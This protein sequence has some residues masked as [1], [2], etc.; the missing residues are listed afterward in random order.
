[1]DKVIDKLIELSVEVKK[2][3]YCNLIEF[4][5]KRNLTTK[6]HKDLLFIYTDN[7]TV[8]LSPEYE[9]PMILDELGNC[10]LSKTWDVISHKAINKIEDMYGEK[11]KEIVFVGK[12]IS[13]GYN[14][15][16]KNNNGE[17]FSDILHKYDGM[18]AKI[19]FRI[20][21]RGDCE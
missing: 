2:G 13:D 19:I 3:D 11:R 7:D 16:I 1:M 17:Y 20:I 5:N 9:L 12:I 14:A 10:F 4:A 18:C 15:E 6:K 21:N 8:V